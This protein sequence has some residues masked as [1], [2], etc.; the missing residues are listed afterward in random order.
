MYIFL[1]HRLYYLNNIYNKNIHRCYCLNKCHEYNIL[2]YEY[3]ENL[4]FFLERKQ[5][6]MDTTIT[7]ID[8][9]NLDFMDNRLAIY[10]FITIISC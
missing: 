6:N 1:N 9:I 2:L 4:F 3:N 7:K 8:S 10:S 5:H